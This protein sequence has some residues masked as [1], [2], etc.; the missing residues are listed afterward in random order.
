MAH[1][2]SLIAFHST[3]A[4]EFPRATPMNAWSMKLFLTSGELSVAVTPRS[5]RPAQDHMSARA[6]ADWGV[7]GAR[8][9]PHRARRGGSASVCQRRRMR[10]REQEGGQGSRHKDEDGRDAPPPGAEARGCHAGGSPKGGIGG[11]VPSSRLLWNDIL[12]EWCGC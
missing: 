4:N 10:R 2:V 11:P 9:V 12:G 7:R 3:F 5:M 1:C 6:C 8:E